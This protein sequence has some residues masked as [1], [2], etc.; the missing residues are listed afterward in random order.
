MLKKNLLVLSG[1]LLLFVS[2]IL[3][4]TFLDLLVFSNLKNI[5]NP[6][7][8]Q[9]GLVSAPILF[10]AL[11]YK[12]IRKNKPVWQPG[13]GFWV[14]YVYISLIGIFAKLYGFYVLILGFL[15][16]AAGANI[17]FFLFEAYRNWSDISITNYTKS[18]KKQVDEVEQI[19]D[20]Y[21][22]PMI[23][24][25]KQSTLFKAPEVTL[26][27]NLGTPS[28]DTA[29]SDL[30]ACP[31]CAED[32]KAKAKKCKHCGEWLEKL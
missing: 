4:G 5:F 26:D 32:I 10:V 21:S 16:P 9:L 28:S 6:L 8:N 31:F 7:F 27:S 2:C 25:E 22:Q 30:I 12:L 29:G 20:N 19:N 1:A 23:E 17:I 11:W 24:I 14:R 13:R 18:T 15:L 3:V